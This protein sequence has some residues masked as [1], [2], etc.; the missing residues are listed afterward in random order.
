MMLFA[1]LIYNHF[2]GKPEES[3]ELSVHKKH[4]INLQEFSFVLHPSAIETCKWIKGK[5]CFEQVFYT[6]VRELLILYKNPVGDI[7]S[8]V[9]GIYGIL[10][11]FPQ[12]LGTN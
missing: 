8:K 10:V 4:P 3:E 6:Y 2:K 5:I 7:V 1:G 12:K 11:W 9:F